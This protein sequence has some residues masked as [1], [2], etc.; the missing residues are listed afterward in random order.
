MARPAGPVR[1]S[2]TH[3]CKVTD[4]DTQFSGAAHLGISYPGER[5][6]IP[7]HGAAPSYSSG[8]VGGGGMSRPWFPLYCSDYQSDTLHLSALESGVYLGL[9]MLS[10]G[11]GPLTDP[12]KRLAGA[13][14]GPVSVVESILLEFWTQTEKGWINKRLEE[15]RL[16]V[17]RRCTERSESGRRGAAKRWGSGNT[18]SDSGSDTSS[19]NGSANGS[20]IANGYYPQPQPQSQEDLPSGTSLTTFGMLVDS[21]PGRPDPVP[22]ERI[23]VLWNEMMCPP[24][25]RCEKLTSTRKGY[26]RQRWQNELPT[27]EEWENFFEHIR[28][29]PFLMGQTPAANGRVPFRATLEW[30]TRPNNY[31]KIYEGRYHGS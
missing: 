23:R 30:V 31:A 19:A 9:L 21:P 3:S 29:S 8:D 7:R 26:I 22:F 4:Q 17:E 13:V 2:A 1:G 5:L 14:R 27:L 10:W 16:K 28:E 6:F 20:A 18:G 11:R 12:P 25:L 15:E 24:L